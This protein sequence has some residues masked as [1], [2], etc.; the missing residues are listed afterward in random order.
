MEKIV[1]VLFTYCCQN[2]YIFDITVSFSFCNKIQLLSRYIKLQKKIT[3]IG[4]I[5][6]TKSLPENKLQTLIYTC[7]FL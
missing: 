5:V 1:L 6:K 2:F 4:I 7:T 3:D